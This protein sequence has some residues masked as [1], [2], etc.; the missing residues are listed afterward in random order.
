MRNKGEFFTLFEGCL[1]RGGPMICPR[2]EVS[3]NLCTRK[4][5]LEDSLK[6]E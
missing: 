3:C 2:E 1:L 5:R 4:K 6:Q